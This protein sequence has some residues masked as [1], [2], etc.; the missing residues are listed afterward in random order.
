MGIKL[1][2]E[3]EAESSQIKSAGE[4][5]ETRRRRRQ[6]RLKLLLFVLAVVAVLGAIAG[7]MVLRLEQVE[8]EIEDLL[9]NTVDAEVAALRLG[10]WETFATTQRSASGDWMQRQQELFNDYQLLKQEHT[11]QLTGRIL[12]LILDRQRARVT[13]EEIID[14][15]PY[16]QIWFYWRYEDGWRHVPPDYT[17]WGEV[18]RYDGQHVDIRY[19]AVDT[20]LATSLGP[21][22]DQWVQSGCA[23]L[24]CSTIP[25]VMVEILPDEGLEL[26]WDT[27]NP[28]L[29]QVPS[30]YLGRARA[31][32][33]FDPER[34]LSVA[35]ILA[36]RLVTL[37]TNNLQPVYPHDV[38]YLRQA[39][40]S[41]LVGRFVQMNT[42]SFL[43]TSLAQN[44]GDATVGRLL[45]ALR[46][47]SDVPVLKDVTGVASL[48][49]A[50][51]DWRDYLTWRLT[52]E[53]EL[54]RRKDETNFLALYDTREDRVRELA[55]QR[56]TATPVEVQKTVV[57][58]PVGTSTDGTP[59]IRAVIQ[60]G[61][62]ATN[63]EEILFRLV[64]GLWLRA[65]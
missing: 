34:Q 9:R 51:L 50:N 57:S 25:T 8:F 2:W 60:I 24:G 12:D 3:I 64:N 11:L 36:E 27:N 17:F 6:S 16:S 7:F 14:G 37:A 55:Y 1:D 20:A 56:L 62:E 26:S 19:Q 63:R 30:A 65:S 33:P 49:Q 4:D 58:A 15:V 28:W 46:L 35:N 44:Y 45:Q 43:I 5:P 61:D 10:D 59:E 40:V 52:V 48:E 42:N 21:R 13:V 31:D 38:Y 29:L 22:L 54:L 23:A 53:A 18:L 41:W 32:Q 39:A 47:D